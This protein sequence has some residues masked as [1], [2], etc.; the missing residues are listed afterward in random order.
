MNIKLTTLFCRNCFLPTVHNIAT[1]KAAAIF[2]DPL[3]EIINTTFAVHKVLVVYNNNNNDNNNNN[4]NNN[5]FP[6]VVKKVGL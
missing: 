6:L 5:N 2:P 4:N 3:R 1:S